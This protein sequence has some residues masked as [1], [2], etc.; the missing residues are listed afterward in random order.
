MARNEK[1]EGRA[2]LKSNEKRRD[3]EAD[4]AKSKPLKQNLPMVPNANAADRK[5][6]K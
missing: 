1:E 2:K 3:P 4:R 6:R 5:S